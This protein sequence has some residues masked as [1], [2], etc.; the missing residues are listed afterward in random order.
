MPRK[1]RAGF[2][3][4]ELLVVIVI[5]TLLM[6][7]LLP[8]LHSAREAA[9]RIQCTNNLKQLGLALHQYE[10]THGFF[11]PSMVLKGRY[12]KIDWVGV[13]SV[14]V[15]LLLF[16]EQGPL[17]NAVNFQTSDPSQN[18]TVTSQTIGVFLCPSEV[19]P[20]PVNSDFGPTAVTSYGWCMGDWYVFGGIGA[21]PTSGSFGPNLGRRLSHFTDGLSQTMLA[22]EVRGRQYLRTNCGWLSQLTSVPTSPAGMGP[23]SMDLSGNLSLAGHSSWADGRV[24]QS[25]MTTAWVPNT[26]V[27]LNVS[28]EDAT[29]PPA[30]LAGAQVDQDLVGTRESDGGPT[31]AAI[32]SRSYHP[33]GVNILLG[34]GSVRF[35]QNSLTLPVWRGLSSIAGGEII[36]ADQY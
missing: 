20:Q 10:S 3:L 23:Q 34:D 12:T 26:K 19:D 35:A 36:S 31:F 33:G 8:A 17:Y 21:F 32:T 6:S 5:L 7:F 24:D 13:Q 28:S 15:R 25:G 9:R 11:P 2:T 30:T 18:A 27:T 22:S 4:I 29:T 16:L 1:T 14:N